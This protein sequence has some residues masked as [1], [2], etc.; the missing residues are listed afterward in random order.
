MLRIYNEKENDILYY[1]SVTVYTRNT[2]FL[3]A[4]CHFLLNSECTILE[5]FVK[6][7][8][9]SGHMNTVGVYE[10]QY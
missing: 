5:I 3:L 8:E 9:G 2:K 7:W 4:G 1:S 10:R 6:I